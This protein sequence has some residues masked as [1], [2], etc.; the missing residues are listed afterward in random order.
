MFHLLQHVLIFESNKQA[1][2]HRSHLHLTPLIKYIKRQ[3]NLTP[4][5]QHFGSAYKS[6]DMEASEDG[7]TGGEMGYRL[8]IKFKKKKK[9]KMMDVERSHLNPPLSCMCSGDA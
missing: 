5:H 4:F 6:R 3:L 8:Y 2:S 9:K 7:V 1:Y